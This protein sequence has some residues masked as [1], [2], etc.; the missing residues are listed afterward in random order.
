MNAEI[1]KLSAAADE[2]SEFL[3]SMASPVR[4]RLLCAVAGREA[5][6]GELAA[7]L[8]VRQSVASQH[9][10]LLRKDGLVRSRREGQTMWYGLADDRVIRIVDVLQATFCPAPDEAARPRKGGAA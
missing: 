8:G 9:L 5:S 10:A 6:V 2:A 7:L 4:L 3:K 1:A